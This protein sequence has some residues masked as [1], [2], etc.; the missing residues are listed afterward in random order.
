VVDFEKVESGAEPG[1]TEVEG[2]PVG[3]FWKSLVRVCRDKEVRGALKWLAAWDLFVFYWSGTLIWKIADLW[4][5][6][7]AFFAFCA[8]AGILLLLLRSVMHSSLGKLLATSD[9]MVLLKL[10]F[11]IAASIL[12]AAMYYAFISKRTYSQLDEFIGNLGYLGLLMPQEVDQLA[13][14][15]RIRTYLGRFEDVYG[16]LP[17]GKYVEELIAQTHLSCIALN[18]KEPEKSKKLET[19][20]KLYGA[21]SLSMIIL[22]SFTTSLLVLGWL[23]VLAPWQTLQGNILSVL[24]PEKTPANF[25]FLGAYFFS[26][27]VLWRRYAT[28]DLYAPAF[29]MVSSRILVSVILISVVSLIVMEENQTPADYLCVLGFIIGVFPEV[30]WELIKKRVTPIV[31]PSLKQTLPLSDLDGLTLWE[32]SRLKEEGIENISHMATADIV[33]LLLD[34]RFYPNRIIEWIDQA[35][36]YMGLSTGENGN[37]L[38]VQLQM[39]GIRTSSALLK[40]HNKSVPWKSLGIDE[41]SIDA[42]ATS[43]QTNPNMKLVMHWKDRQIPE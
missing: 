32:E 4:R 13:Y 11:I 31:V 30:A 9:Q 14:K 28:K 12:P 19:P 35:I 39:H 2:V 29:V 25:A 18:R 24:T 17:S 23:L 16:F 8:S 42:L 41:N 1:I 15:R 3:S 40:V 26:I 27:E 20:F 5:K 33:D 22:V 36:L 34:T 38:K 21:T 43:L 37:T 10:L 6:T 7:S